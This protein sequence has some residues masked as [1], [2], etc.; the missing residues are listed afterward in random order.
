MK[1][2]RYDYD[3]EIPEVF[4]RIAEIAAREHARLFVEREQRADLEKIT[5]KERELQ[6][7]PSRE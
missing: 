2:A 5:Q 7:Q 6:T 3:P 4:Y 1:H